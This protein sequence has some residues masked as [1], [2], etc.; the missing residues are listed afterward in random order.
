[1]FRYTKAQI[2]DMAKE[3]NYV[4]DTLE[5]A[6]RLEDILIF[7]NEDV[8][9]K[10]FLGLKGGT[11]INLIVF[12]MKRLSV[13]ID[14]DFLINLSRE[15]MTERREIIR[16][17]LKGYMALQGYQLSGKSR[18]SHALDSFVFSY[19][20]LGGTGDNLK[21]EINYMNRE[22]I[23]PPV[24]R[25]SLIDI[26]E[27]QTEIV[28]LQDIELF[29]SKIKALLERSAARDFYDVF[30]M[31]DVELFKREELNLLRKSIVFYMALAQNESRTYSPEKIDKIDFMQIKTELLPVI[32]RGTYFELETI[33][34]TVKEFI[35]NLMQLTVEEEK[36]LSEF[37]VGNYSP[38]L[39]FSDEKILERIKKHPMALWRVGNAQEANKE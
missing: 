3:K 18:F 20:N 9:V 33:K 35:T 2:S 30:N 14:L 17:R 5:K 38:E 7:I 29:G 22:H 26:Y 31:I 11:A 16:N 24:K 12:K 32:Q 8:E 21:I 39:L 10:D 37:K 28:I 6:M 13:D 23:L 27:K 34:K 15:E 19:N 36:F 25:K 4:R 1:M